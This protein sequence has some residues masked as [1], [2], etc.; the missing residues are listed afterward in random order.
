MPHMILAGEIDIE[1]MAAGFEP[2]VFRWGP[3]VL[4]V[5][6]S[7]IRK[8]RLAM[9]VEGVVVE[10]SRPLHPVVVVGVS[11]GK[12]QVRL[13]PRVEVERTRAVQRFLALVAADLQRRGAGP[14]RTTNLP[15]EVWH[16]VG[17]RLAEPG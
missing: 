3:V 7:W 9:L 17:L 4:K 12:T 2:T 5:A 14:L 10:L 8:D 13:W 11:D 6:E 16:D 1:S 15:D